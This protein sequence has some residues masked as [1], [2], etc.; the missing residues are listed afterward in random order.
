MAEKAK[1]IYVCQ[2]CGRH[3]PRW[4]GRCDSCGQWQ[5]I[6][7]QIAEK[8]SFAPVSSLQINNAITSIKA[9]Q[10]LQ[11]DFSRFTS[12]IGE[13]DRCL[14]RSENGAAGMVRGSVV[15]I[16]GEPGIGKSTLLTQVLINLSTKYLRQAKL[17]SSATSSRILYLCGEESPAQI[18]IRLQRLLPKGINLAD[19]PLDYFTSGDVDLLTAAIKKLP[20]A[21]LIVDS[22]QTLKTQDLLGQAGGLGQIKECVERVVQTV[23]SLHIPTFLIGHVTKDGGLAGPKVLEHLVDA[24][25]AL[26]GERSGELRFLRVLKNR[27]GASDEVGVFKMNE[28]GM[29]EVVNPSEYFLQESQTGVPGSGVVCILEGTRALLTEVQ[30]LVTPSQ[31]AMPRRVGRGI[32]LSRV[33]VLAAVLGK[34]CHLPLGTAD[35]FLSV[36]GGMKI[37]EAGIDLGLALALASSLKEKPL[38]AKT[39]FIGEVGLMGEIRAVSSLERRIKEAKRLGYQQVYAYPAQRRVKDLLEQLQII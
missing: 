4:Q 1:I 15:L 8:K 32:D 3:Y 21:L 38:P 2:N 25:F 22:I 6:A 12:G 29:S 18:N 23:K 13:L 39:V 11:L 27:F 19:L 36:V 10:N 5:T 31:L 37:Q 16:G 7:E 9:S 24:I 33:Q 26:E 35:I 20:P 17:Q 28:L 34:H 14:G 30:A